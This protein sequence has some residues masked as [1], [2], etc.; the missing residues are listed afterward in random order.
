MSSYD[1]VTSKSGNPYSEDDFAS[2]FN[3]NYSASMNGI[4]VPTG[5][6]YTD[7]NSYVNNPELHRSEY[8]FQFS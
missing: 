3:M 1:G 7:S 6:S 8:S 4:E 5:T 2:H